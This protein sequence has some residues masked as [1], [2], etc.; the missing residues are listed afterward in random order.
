MK[1]KKLKEKCDGIEKCIKEYFV[2][3]WDD[4]LRVVD[5]FVECG[6]IERDILKLLEFGE[7]CVDLRGE[8]E[9]WFGMV[10]FL[11]S[12]ENLDVVIFVGFV[13]VFCMDNCLVICYYGVL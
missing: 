7:I 11:L 12:I 8:N 6:A 10:M 5:I 13:G 1:L 9:L 3:G 2:V 4:F